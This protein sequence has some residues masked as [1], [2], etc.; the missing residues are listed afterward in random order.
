MYITNPQFD[1]YSA[2]GTRVNDQPVTAETALFAGDIVQFGVIEFQVEE[3]S[4]V[5][6]RQLAPILDEK[7]VPVPSRRRKSSTSKARATPVSMPP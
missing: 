1:L 4:E 5:E 2:N 3:R 7:G 6:D